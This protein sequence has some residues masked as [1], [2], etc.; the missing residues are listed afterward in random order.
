MKINLLLLIICCT[1]NLQAQYKVTFILKDA[2]A[3]HRKEQVYAAGNFN[4]WNPGS[5]QYKFENKGDTAQLSLMLQP[6]TYQFKCTRGNWQKTEGGSNGK[7]ISNRTIVVQ[8]DTVFYIS[9]E[10]WMDDA[11]APPPQKSTASVNVSIISESFFMPQLNRSRRIWLYLPAGYA[12]GNTRYPVLYMQDGQNLFDESTAPYG[13]WGLDECLDSMVKKGSS[14][15]VVGIDHGG[16]K[17]MAEYNP[18]SFRNFGEGEGSSYVEFLVKTLKPYIDKNYRTLAGKENTAVA[19]SSMGGLI[20]TYAVLKY[21]Q[22]FGGAG[23]FSPAYWT[24]PQFETFIDSL[25][26]KISA[27][28]FFYAGEQE[29]TEMVTDMERIADKLALKSDYFIYSVTDGEGKH[30]EA[31]WRKWLPVFYQWMY[32]N[33]AE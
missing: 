21:P 25:P 17:R 2:P 31:A 6:D 4:G 1:A 5:E 29:S 8:S 27:R 24:A 15:I 33:R 11:G 19:G 16:D 20:A 32:N 28:L 30:N 7:D 12:T 10:A 3:A 26:G 23:I 22:V 14:C 9:I 13:E 18:Y